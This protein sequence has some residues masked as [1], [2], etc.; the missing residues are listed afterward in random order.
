[1]SRKDAQLAARD[2][3]FLIY[4]EPSSCG[5]EVSKGGEEEEIQQFWKRQMLSDEGRKYNDGWKTG[6]TTTPVASRDAP[7]FAWR[8]LSS[9]ACTSK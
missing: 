9:Q 8:A 5:V 3:L 2:K 6:I 7:C 4:L 1:L